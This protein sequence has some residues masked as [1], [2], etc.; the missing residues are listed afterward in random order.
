MKYYNTRILYF[1]DIKMSFRKFQQET[2][3]GTRRETIT[4]FF[5]IK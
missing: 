2:I 3:D 4:Q 1:E 5:A